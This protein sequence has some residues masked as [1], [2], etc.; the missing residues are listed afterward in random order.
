MI[1]DRRECYIVIKLKWED[2][3]IIK[4]S[5][6]DTLYGLNLLWVPNRW[7]QKISKFAIFSPLHLSFLMWVHSAL[8]GF[9]CVLIL[10]CCILSR[11]PECVN[12]SWS[13]DFVFQTSS[14]LWAGEFL[15]DHIILVHLKKIF[16]FLSK[17]NQ[18][19]KKV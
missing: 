13:T 16:S 14:I 7:I 10:S 11:V 17:S 15:A 5:V 8:M 6:P 19:H 1:L 12:D 18:F 2:C 4:Q 3:S 9:W